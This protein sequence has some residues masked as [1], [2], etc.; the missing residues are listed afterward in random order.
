MLRDMLKKPGLVDLC[1]C[2]AASKPNDFIWLHARDELCALRKDA[3]DLVPYPVV[4][5]DVPE[6][7]RGRGKEVG[8]VGDLAGVCAAA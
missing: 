6:R 8:Q 7:P 5:F 1:L 3:A 2:V 4:M